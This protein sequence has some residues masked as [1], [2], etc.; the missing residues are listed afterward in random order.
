MNDV[1]NARQRMAMSGEIFSARLREFV[2]RWGPGDLSDLY[3]FQMDMTRLMVEAMRHK[4]DTM[5]F[6]IQTYADH[7]F[8]E[9]ALRPL[10]V[11]HH[12]AKEKAK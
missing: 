4:S 5:S 11:I 2:D 8:A 1:D 9:M 3:D 6:G 10:Q 7:V 12:A